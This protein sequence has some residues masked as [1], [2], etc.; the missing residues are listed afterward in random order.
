MKVNI[1]GNLYLESDDK[2]FVIKEYTGKEDNK[3]KALFKTFGYFPTV[4]QAMKK[5]V[6]MKIKQSN[7]LTLI[8]LVREIEG[9]NQYIQSKLNA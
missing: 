8:E 9:I 5:L 3:G 7:A 2:C 6:Q 4:E 1:E